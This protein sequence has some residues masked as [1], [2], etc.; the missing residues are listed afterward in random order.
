[1]SIFYYF[2]Y[3][4]IYNHT[5]LRTYFFFGFRMAVYNTI[6]DNEYSLRIHQVSFSELKN[7][8]TGRVWN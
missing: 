7:R 8:R 4:N 1:M 6:K 2:N 3:F 5:Y